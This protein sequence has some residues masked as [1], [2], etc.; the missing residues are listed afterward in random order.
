MRMPVAEPVTKIVGAPESIE[1]PVF[2]FEAR[3]SIR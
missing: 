1:L 3:R 2:A